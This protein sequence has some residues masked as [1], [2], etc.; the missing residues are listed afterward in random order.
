MIVV[1]IILLIWMDNKNI[2]YF[3]E[4]EDVKEQ[5]PVSTKW[6]LMVNVGVLLLVIGEILFQGSDEIIHI[7]I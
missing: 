4:T 7:R 2:S 1:A 6:M 5:R 3:L